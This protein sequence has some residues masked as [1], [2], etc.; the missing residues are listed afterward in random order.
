MAVGKGR[1]S[2]RHF[3]YNKQSC[4]FLTKP[5]T[6]FFKFFFFLKAF[7]RLRSPCQASRVYTGV[8]LSAYEHMNFAN[9]NT[10]ITVRTTDTYSINQA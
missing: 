5:H 10:V 9:K 7:P 2:R 4:G 6:I 1:N 8:A 3:D